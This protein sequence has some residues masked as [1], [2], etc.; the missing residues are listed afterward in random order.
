MHFPASRRVIFRH[1]PLDEV[2]CQLRFPRELEL[3]RG[4]PVEFQKRIRDRYPEFESISE[5]KLTIDPKSG[6]S[7]SPSAPVYNFFD[8]G[9]D[10]KVS[11]NSEFLAL[12]SS[13]YTRWEDFEARI[14]FLMNVHKE[15]Y[16]PIYYQRI[17][18]RYKD[19]INRKQLKLT[20]VSWKDLLRPEVAGLF[21]NV[22]DIKDERKN[23]FSSATN[24]HFQVEN[25]KARLVCGTVKHKESGEIGFM[26]DGDYFTEQQVGGITRAINHLRTFNQLAGNVFRWCIKKRLFE[27]LGPTDP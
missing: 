8:Q 5:Q 6:P 10:W 18:L 19:V 1:N 3:D 7:L 26:I 17:G 13:N 23:I 2:I 9:K 12:T 16:D 22:G 25:V 4:L 21:S 11:L 20:K 24:F 15:I 27:A 14:K